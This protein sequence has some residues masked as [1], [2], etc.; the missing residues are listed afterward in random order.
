MSAG[1]DAA[2]YLTDAYHGEVMGEAFFALLAEREREAEPAAKWRLLERLERHV[3]CRL[4]GELERRDIDASEDRARVDEGRAG[5]AAL[6]ALPWQERLGA[7]QKAVRGFVA[8][9]EIAAEAAPQ[10]LNELASFVL[11][12]EHSPRSR[13]GSWQ[14]RE[15]RRA[16]PSQSCSLRRVPRRRRRCSTGCA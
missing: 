8:G 12:H 15:P 1:F 9:F 6:G 10:E 11:R 3:K 16:S 4:R 2:Q 5:A 13:S 7:F 14:A